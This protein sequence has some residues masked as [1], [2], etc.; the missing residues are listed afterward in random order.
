[1]VCSECPTA[2]AFGT[3]PFQ[4][5][6]EQSDGWCGNA[7]FAV[8]CHFLIMKTPDRLTRQALD[9]HIGNVDSNK[10]RGLFIYTGWDRCTTCPGS[11]LHPCLLRAT[12]N[13][14]KK[15]LPKVSLESAPIFSPRFLSEQVRC[16]DIF[17]S[18]VSALREPPYVEARSV[19]LLN[20]NFQLVGALPG[21]QAGQGRARQGRAGQGRAGRQAGRQAGSKAGGQAGQQQADRYR[22]AAAGPH[23]SRDHAHDSQTE[24][25][26]LGCARE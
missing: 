21:R 12:L 1:M 2:G 14:W 16:V 26:G 10:G 15:N 18:L 25:R 23:C 3:S 19:V 7:L 9:K 11:A 20:G 24:S 22:Q 4:W 8:P 5:S 17:G 13:L 6:E